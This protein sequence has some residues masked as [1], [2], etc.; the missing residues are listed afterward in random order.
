MAIGRKMESFQASPDIHTRGPAADEY[1]SCKSPKLRTEGKGEKGLDVGWAEGQNLRRDFLLG[2][3]VQA[4]AVTSRCK[5]ESAAEGRNILALLQ[6]RLAAKL[7]R[8]VFCANDSAV[9][10]RQSLRQACIR[11]RQGR[12]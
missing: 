3:V 5:N 6:N 10:G 9:R 12:S 8:E 11:L 7:D 2:T 1:G 4:H